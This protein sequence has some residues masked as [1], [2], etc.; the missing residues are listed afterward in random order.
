[1][2]YFLFSLDLELATGRFDQDKVRN[3]MFSGDGSQER[4][5][6]LRLIK[7][8]EEY[9]IVGTWATVGHLFHSECE[10]CEICPIMEWKGKYSSFAEV[11]G[12]TNPFW[13]GKD[14]IDSLLSNGNRQEIAFHGYSHKVFDDHEMSSKDA[15][16]EINE[17]LRLAKIDGIT[18]SA[19][20]FPRNV[21]GH[22]DALQKVGMIC[23]R[24]DPK[25]PW[26]IRNKT[27]GRYIKAIDQIL[28]ISNLPIFDLEY[29]MYHGMVILPSSQCFFDLNRK[30]E[31]VLDSI[32]LHNLRFKRVIK[33]IQSA[34]E[35]KKIVHLWA[36]P[37][38]FRTEKDFQKLR[39]IFNCVSAEVNMGRMRSVGMTEMAQLLIEKT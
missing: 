8:F 5:Q 33:G 2:G 9:G 19:V 24:G 17:W 16:I 35:L 36:H 29:E 18:P 23:F 22:L 34:A 3:K 21:I 13:Y 30:F 31:H 39:N 11:Y 15:E 27:F 7:I 12:T 25:R 32:N 10:N 6:I 4:K 20:V 1:M 28:G 14:I 38:D 26:L 37:C